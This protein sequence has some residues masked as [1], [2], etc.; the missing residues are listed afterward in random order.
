MEEVEHDADAP[1]DAPPTAPPA[2][3]P[4]ASDDEEDD[5]VWSGGGWSRAGFIPWRSTK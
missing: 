2:A 1:P 5:G 3:P 4:A